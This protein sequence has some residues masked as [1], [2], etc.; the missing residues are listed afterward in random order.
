VLLVGALAAGIEVA[1]PDGRVTV[2]GDDRWP[3]MVDGPVALDAMHAAWIDSDGDVVLRN[4]TNLPL[5]LML[6]SI[7]PA[8]I[9][10]ESD[11]PCLVFCPTPLQE[12]AS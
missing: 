1:G 11:T 4:E 9:A 6:V 2:L 12:L 5:T 3:M 10:D 8:P 7:E